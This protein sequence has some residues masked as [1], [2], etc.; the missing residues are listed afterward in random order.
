MR[1]DVDVTS[2]K[3]LGQRLK[4]LRKERGLSLKDLDGLSGIAYN[5]ISEYENG[6]LKPSGENLMKLS[7]A[8]GVSMNYLQTGR[9]SDGVS[10]TNSTYE[11]NIN[12]PRDT[13][14]TEII[15]LQLQ[16]IISLT[17]EVKELNIEIR[18][19]NDDLQKEKDEKFELM[20]RFYENK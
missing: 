6:K 1:K 8:L 16:E 19:L 4:I 10:L 17:K 18:R 2:E 12:S 11:N 9:E 5:T 14:S 3:N 20:K 13:S 7:D 15:K